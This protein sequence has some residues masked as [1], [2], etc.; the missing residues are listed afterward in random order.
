MSRHELRLLNGLMGF[1]TMNAQ[2][3]PSPLASLAYKHTGLERPFRVAIDGQVRNP[4]PELV[5][6]S[7]RSSHIVLVEIKSRGVDGRQ[8]KG[9]QQVTADELHGQGFCEEGAPVPAQKDIAYICN[10]SDAQALTED[11]GRINTELPIISASEENW[12]L[13]S[14]V[15]INETWNQVFGGG[16]TVASDDWP[17][18]F[19]RIDT[20]STVGELAAYLVRDVI[21]LLLSQRSFHLQELCE[22][23]IS[24]WEQRG[25]ENQRRMRDKIREALGRISQEELKPFIQLRNNRN[26]VDR[27]TKSPWTA[28]TIDRINDLAGQFVYR[29]DH[30]IPFKKGQP[31]LFGYEDL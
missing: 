11:F 7:G 28:I 31:P 22:A 5:S 21:R 2:T 18:H 23:S 3:W 27:V 25:S 20:D 13:Y 19:V 12:Q 4:T 6:H 1:M 9:Y 30:E 15:F 8:A 24:H 26:E 16:L 17:T 10:E 14:G 29:Q